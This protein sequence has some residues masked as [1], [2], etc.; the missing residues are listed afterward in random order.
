MLTF[1]AG[2]FGGEK[3]R[4]ASMATVVGWTRS[5]PSSAVS[6]QQA[7]ANKQ[8]REQQGEFNPEKQ[9]RGQGHSCP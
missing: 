6:K 5:P 8:R 3:P 7:Q 4:H 2:E 1:V 9:R